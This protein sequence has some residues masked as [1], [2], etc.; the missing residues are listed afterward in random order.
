MIGTPQMPPQV[1]P[2]AMGGDPASR[3]SA[4]VGMPQEPPMPRVPVDMRTQQASAPPPPRAYRPQDY[5]AYGGSFWDRYAGSASAPNPS[6]YR[7]EDYPQRAP[8][9]PYN[10][11]AYPDVSWSAFWDRLLGRERKAHGGYMRGGYPEMI[12]MPEP[13]PTMPMRPGYFSTGGGQ[14][15]VQPDGQG[16]G[17]SD[18][19][20]AR[21]SPGEY[22][23]DGDTVALLGDGNGEAGARKMDAF[24]ESVRKHKGKALAKG[25]FAPAAKKDATEYLASSPI[26][27][28]LRRRAR[29]ED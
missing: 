10:P 19:I 5:P 27:D 20:E 2:A 24:R 16:D 6:A 23:L 21:L 15:Y 8:D 18:H 22:V 14:N 28:G 4:M 25:K 26:S 13:A 11:A 3:I 17:R 1:D 12:G 7:A 9:G 29:K